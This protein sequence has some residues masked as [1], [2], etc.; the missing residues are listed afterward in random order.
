[1]C[2]THKWVHATTTDSRGHGE[3]IGIELFQDEV[4]G[5]PN[6][7]IYLRHEDGALYPARTVNQ[8]VHPHHENVVLSWAARYPILHDHRSK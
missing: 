4:E 5:V 7:A 8:T 6:T 2:D 1:M 3:P